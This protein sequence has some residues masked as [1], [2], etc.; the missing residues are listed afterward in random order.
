MRKG[1]KM[2]FLLTALCFFA[3]LAIVFGI[4]IFAIGNAENQSTLTENATVKQDNIWDCY[5]YI[6]SVE[7]LSLL[8]V[9]IPYDDDKISETSSFQEEKYALCHTSL[10]E[11]CVQYSHVFDGNGEEKK[12]QNGFQ[13][14]FPRN[15][16]SSKAICTENCS[17][18]H[19]YGAWI[20]YT[21]P[22]CVDVGIDRR[23]CERC[24]HYEIREIAPIGHKT[25][26][27]S[28]QAP[29]CTEVGWSAYVSCK[30]CAYSTY[31]EIP[32]TGHIYGDWREIKAP[33][34][35]EKGSERRDCDGCDHFETREI[36]F[37]GHDEIL[38]SAKAPTCTEIGWDAYVTCSRCD[39]T[40][41]VELSAL[42]HSVILHTAKAPTCT[43]IGWNAYVNCS[44]CD[45]STYM[46]RPAFGHVLSSWIIDRE[47]THQAD[48]QKHK[49]CTVCGETLET[50]IIPMRNHSY[51]SVITSPNCLERGYTTHTCS[52]CGN[53]YIDDYVDALGHSY[54]EWMITENPT[55]ILDGQKQRDC[56][57]CDDYEICEVAAIGHSTVHHMA[58]APTCTEVG[59]DAYVSCI[60]CDYSTYTENSAIGHT[61][62]D[63]IEYI[64]STC[65][66]VGIDRRD[67]ENC[68]HYEIREIAPIGHQTIRRSAQAPTCTEVGWHA[69]VT[70]KRCSYSTYTEIPATGHFYGDWTVIKASTCLEKGNERR[71]CYGCDAFETREIESLGHAEI[72]HSSQAPT[73]I[74]VGWNAY[75]TCSR[76]DYTTYVEI[77]A[78]GH[79]TSDWIIDVEATYEADGSKHKECTVCGETLETSIIPMLTHSYDSIVT[80][81]TCTER[82]YTTHTCSDCGDIYIDDYV[83]ATGHTYGEWSTTT[84]PTC[85][86]IGTEQR[87][88]KN[89]AHFE[90][91]DVAALGHDEV[92]HDAKAPTCTEIGWSANVTC[93]RC[94]YT[95]YVEISATGHTSSDWMI[96]A[97]ATYEADGSKHKECTVCGETL[98]TS[99]IPMLTHS[100]VAVVTPPICTERGYT[101]HT[102]SDCGDVYIDDFVDETGHIYSEWL[103]S[104]VPSC[105]VGGQE[106]RD[107]ENCD[108]FETRDVATLEH[109][110]VSHPAHPATCTDIGWNAYET[111]LRCDHTTYVEIPANGHSYRDWVET[112]APTCTEDGEKEKECSVCHNIVTEVVDKLG[113]DEVTHNA[114]TATC[115][116]IGWNAYVTCSRC[117]YTTY[118]EIPKLDHS[119]SEWTETTAPTCLEKGEEHRACSNCEHYETR[120]LAALNHD[121]IEHEAKVPSCTEVGW[122]AYVSCSRC[123]YTMYIELPSKGGHTFGEWERIIDP[124]PDT[125]GMDR[126]TCSVCGNHENRDV[127]ALGYLQA[128]INAVETLS[129]NESAENTYS[130]LYSALQLY[131]KLTEDE[132]QKANEEYLVLQEAINDYNS[133]AETANTELKNATEIAFIPISASFTF[134]AA[135]WFLLKKKFW[136]K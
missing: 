12:E 8:N 71:D 101:T 35:L 121:R 56:K 20:E 72:S 19:T 93:S 28:A 13:Y 25:I 100:Y 36:A 94:D 69:Y 117:D 76:C 136:M 54:E 129:E 80:P 38:H 52:G 86:T 9:A 53:S 7:S 62:G 17:T 88:C 32:A 27:R 44:R 127:A 89:C 87:N 96:D 21:A 105:V 97:E 51:V 85:T 113:H 131:S 2:T 73:C 108:H 95:T 70:C 41:Y 124:T 130:E 81:P 83:E 104:T 110:I 84:A 68:D 47:A 57:N 58:Q 128:F 31:T 39:Y 92:N 24:D 98:E 65:V 66:G 75:V 116:Q 50:S 59:W 99:I 15:V 91:C 112:T 67:C 43:E 125:A 45:Y 120:E 11:S 109:D 23:D 122:D 34:C 103:T 82:G 29:T 106:R 134:L 22:T 4:S 61:Y 74:D 26:R 37:L 132:K 46:E 16:E 123:D 55:C 102:C 78:I 63:W 10:S 114:Q 33:T 18:G 133:K 42:G 6:G 77:P 49:E 118:G 90:T 48:G 40:T 60:R 30:R 5:V 1:K 115:E 111:C 135:L 14:S 119:M 3:L 79:T 126:R 107:C 64:A